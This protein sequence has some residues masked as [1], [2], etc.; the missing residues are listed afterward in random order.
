MAVGATVLVVQS[1]AHSGPGRWSGWL[2][3]G[4]VGMEV[5]RADAGEELPGRLEHD[6]L[7]VLGGGYLPDDDERAPWLA[8]T[9]A[10]VEQALQR[11]VPM[12]G[13]CLGGQMLAQVAG[14]AVEGAH[15]EPEF[16]ST[17]LTL[18]HEAA[19]DA[20]F[21]ELPE[22]PTAVENHV[23]AIVRLPQGAHWLASSERCAYQAFRVG[24]AAWGVQFHPEVAPESLTRWS[25]ARLER[26]G[27]DRE[28]LHRVALRED[29]T[30]AAVWRKVALR[31]AA[32]V[33]NGR[34]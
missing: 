26:Y 30:A 13:I 7:V 19:D 27:A 2:A 31:F 16:G 28:E 34:G 9:R 32:R 20:L 17:V 10:L 23:D 6:A 5:V 18:R 12:F 8:G 25:A 29:L 33:R 1:S 15:G 3:E 4:G 14:G 21:R 24:A 22:R 11:G